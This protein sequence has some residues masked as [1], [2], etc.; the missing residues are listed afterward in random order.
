MA[1]AGL[2]E[3][4]ERD[5]LFKKLLILPIIC[6]VICGSVWRWVFS[7]YGFIKKRHYNK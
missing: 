2:D 4:K 1:L 5:K 3:D 7:E 6:A